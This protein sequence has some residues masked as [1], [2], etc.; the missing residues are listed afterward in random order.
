MNTTY[1]A[2]LIDVFNVFHRMKP[3]FSKSSTIQ[4]KANIC[5]EYIDSCKKYL[6]QDGTL[7]LL[8]DA[9]P[10]TDLSIFKSFTYNSDFE[11]RLTDRQKINKMYKSNRKKRESNLLPVIYL[12]KAFYEYRG[13]KIVSVYCDSYEAD[14]YVETIVPNFN[15]IAMVTTDEDW[16]RYLSNNPKHYVTMIN[17]TFE[18][19]F[20]Y[21]DFEKKYNFKPSI[22]SVCAFKS[23]FGDKSDNI[24]GV[25]TSK[26]G[27]YAPSILNNFETTVFN[28]IKE[29]SEN[30]TDTVDDMINR[31]SLYNF[32]NYMNIPMNCERE[33]FKMIFS[34]ESFIKVD[35]PREFVKNLKL[36]KSRCKSYKKHAF[37][38]KE[39]PSFN[40]II[41]SSLGRA[42]PFTQQPFSFGISIKK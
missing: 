42:V 2:I 39:N 19:P 5:I 9:I 21:E 33:F 14:D 32:K 23:L 6:T 30:N 40:K 28:F 20:L 10:K 17:K 34:N 1:E 11:E 8:F 13:D 16:C 31:I 7:F 15:S 37:A 12:I 41:E 27:K 3:K 4:D 24:E 29:L 35:V 22:K 18:E 25:F 38:K 26:S 36:I